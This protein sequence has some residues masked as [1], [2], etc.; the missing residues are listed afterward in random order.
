MTTLNNWLQRRG[1]QKHLFI[2]AVLIPMSIIFLLFWV[3]PLANGFIG[4]LTS[5]RAFDPAREFIGFAN[6]ARLLDDDRFW[7]ALGNT[8]RYA[9]FYLPLATGLALLLALAINQTGRLQSFFR[10]V[11]FLPV[12]TSVISTALIWSWL[13][14][15]RFGLFN[16]LLNLLNLPPQGFLRSPDQ[17]LASIAVYAVWKNLGFNLVLFLAGL[18]GISRTYYEAARVDGASGWQVF[19]YITMPLLQPTILLVIITS[20]IKIMQDFGPIYMMTSATGNDLPGG[21]LNSTLVLSVYQWEVAFRELNLGYGNTIG[22]ALF[23]IILIITLVQAR[24]LRRRWEL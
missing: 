24:L 15:P 2:L 16:Q 3:Y 21:P 6:Y 14:Q 10:T 5:W 9:L 19:R 23:V 13:Y 20:I 8:A 22:I 12:V 11:Y 1:T 18:S 17:A 4:S 7:I